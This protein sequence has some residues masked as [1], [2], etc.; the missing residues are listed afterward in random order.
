MRLKLPRFQNNI[1]LRWVLVV[2]LVLPTFGAVTLVGY[3]SYRSGRQAVEKLAHQLIKNAGQQ[4][5]QELD[6]YLQNAHEFNQRQI[7]A[8][9]SGA[10][11][12]QNL[13]QLH[14]YLILQHRQTEDLT[15]LLFGTPQGDFRVSHRVSPRDY[16]VTT[17]L[18]PEEL[19]FEAAISD[20]LNPSINQTYSINEDGELMRLIEILQNIDVRDR[21]WYRQAVETGKSGWTPP[22]QIGSTNLL[23]LNAYDPLYD[24]SRQL[25]GVFAVNISLNQLSEFLRNLEIGKSGEVYIIER[26]GLLIADSTSEM[27]YSVSGK[28]DLSGTAEPGTIVFQRR[29]PSQIP[30][31]V[32]KDSYEYLL[33]KFENLATLQSPQALNFQKRGDRYFLNISP[34]KD[35]YGLDWLIVTVIPESDFMA[36][37]HRNTRTTVLLCL[38]TMGLAIASGLLIADRLTIRITRFSRI[39]QELANGNLTQ[40]LPADLPIVE[41][42]GLAQSFNRMA[43]QLQQSFDWLENALEASEEKFTTIF[44]TIPDPIAITNLTE[45]RFLEVNNRMSEFY[46]YSRQ[47]LLGRTAL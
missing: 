23:A 33:A 47:E 31:S 36:E 13:D 39:S 37:I 3:L 26:N 4:V 43:D 5:T 28:P 11:N 22:F 6:H 12:L 1:S 17:L 25:L 35:K 2:L 19:P 38:L 7:A 41:M 44:R 29:F 16:G 32:I 34:Y 30:N 24:K 40:R 46:G 10:I 27:P 45:G 20:P 21:P 14:R 18:K 15:T 42:K 9:Q 8:I